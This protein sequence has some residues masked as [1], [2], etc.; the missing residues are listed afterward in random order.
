MAEPSGL[1]VIE[2]DTLEQPL[3]E[4]QYKILYADGGLYVGF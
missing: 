1:V 2:P 4:M 3:L